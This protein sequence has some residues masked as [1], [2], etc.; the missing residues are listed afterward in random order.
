MSSEKRIPNLTPFTDA[1]MGMQIP[2]KTLFYNPRPYSGSINPIWCEREL[3][4]EYDFTTGEYQKNHIRN[5]NFSDTFDYISSGRFQHELCHILLGLAFLKMGRNP[6][7]FDFGYNGN[8]LAE[9]IVMALEQPFSRFIEG[10]SG[11]SNKDFNFETVERHVRHIH[12]NMTNDD[13]QYYRVGIYGL[14]QR[15]NKPTSVFEYWREGHFSQNSKKIKADIQEEKTAVSSA[16]LADVTKWGEEFKEL[17]EWKYQDIES[18]CEIV[19][20]LI[21][22]IIQTMDDV[23]SSDQDLPSADRAL[24]IMEL[25]KTFYVSDFWHFINAENTQNIS[26]RIGA[27]DLDDEELRRKFVQN[28]RIGSSIAFWHLD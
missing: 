12:Q 5:W 2:K 26:L 1:S 4:I 3:A 10:K 8:K 6:L 11:Y 7:P 14:N 20:P 25:M 22:K 28:Y 18:V 13:N 9:V 19:C 17:E 16:K 23:I 24:A 15:S 21:L 27:Y